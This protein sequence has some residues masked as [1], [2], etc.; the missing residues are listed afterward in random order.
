MYC[1]VILRKGD[2]L[3]WMLRWSTGMG[4]TESSARFS[5]VPGVEAER[6]DSNLLVVCY[7]SKDGTMG[8]EMRR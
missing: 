5:G 3:E 8:T 1:M 4:E 2:G 7:R 6:K